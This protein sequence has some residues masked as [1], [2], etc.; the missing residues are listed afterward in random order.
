MSNANRFVQAEQELDTLVVFDHFDKGQVDTT[1]T[2]TTTDSGTVVTGNAAGGQIVLT[3]SDGTVADN[4]EAYLATPN[5]VFLLAAGNDLYGRARVKFSE[6]AA[7]RVNVAFGFQNSVGA[8][9]LIDD[10]GG[11]KVSGDTLAIFKEDSGGMFWY[12]CAYCNGTGTTTKTNYAISPA[13]WYTLEIFAQDNG[14]GTFVVTYK[15]NGAY[16]RDTNNNIIRHSVTV[17]SATAMAMWL[18]VKLGAA[19]NN[20]TLTCDHWLGKQKVF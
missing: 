15:V 5:A 3:P 14:D 9:S 20:D 12:C 10:G 4:D 1:A 16:L 11:P 8:N 18:G 7:N 19:T 6:V 2:K 13:T 17:A